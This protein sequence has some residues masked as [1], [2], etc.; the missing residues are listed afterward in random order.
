[1]GRR[2]RLRASQPNCQSPA[3]SILI[4]RKKLE[5]RARGFVCSD[6][7]R[8]F[9]KNPQERLKRQLGNARMRVPFSSQAT[10]ALNQMKR[11]SEQA[12]IT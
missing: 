12:S 9:F 4:F 3:F 8:N 2:T 10:L 6:Y 11:V 5:K 7:C 1:M